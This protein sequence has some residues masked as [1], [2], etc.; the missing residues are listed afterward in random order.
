MGATAL[1]SPEPEG[2]FGLPAHRP[3][4]HHRAAVKLD[5]ITVVM[6]VSSTPS[7]M[8]NNSSRGSLVSVIS[9]PPTNTSVS[10]SPEAM[11]AQSSTPSLVPPPLTLPPDSMSPSYAVKSPSIH[12]AMS[13]AIS[14]S[15]SPS[16]LIRRLSRGAQSRI[17]R[18]RNSNTST[19][20]DQSAGPVIMR[21]RSNSNKLRSDSTLDV[22]DF[23][24]EPHGEVAVEDSADHVYSASL[25]SPETQAGSSLAASRDG[26]AP[27]VPAM[28][29]LGSRITKVTKRRGKP[30]LLQLD[31]DSGKVFWDPHKSSK[32]FYIDDI[33]YIRVGSEARE[34]REAAQ[35]SAECESRWFTVIF[36]TPDNAKGRGALRALHF[37]ADEP[38]TLQAWVDGINQIQQ[39]RIQTM[40][41][42]AKG[43]ENCLQELWRRETG[44]LDAD[45]TRL[46]FQAVNNLCK[47]LSINCSESLLRAHFNQADCGHV[48]SIDFDQFRSFV[49]KLRKRHDI[50]QVFKNAKPASK[51]ELD[52]QSFLDF[53]VNIQGIQVNSRL[54][55][56]TGT[57]ER[58][59]KR[60]R[61]DDEPRENPTTMNFAAFQDLMMHP[62]ISGATNGR[63][64]DKPLD[65][66]L[67]EYFVSS[68]H[69]TY[70]TGRQF[71]DDCSTEAY[72]S[73]LTR[74]CRCVEIDCWDGPGGRPEVRHGRNFTKPVL[75]SDCIHVINEHAFRSSA[76]PL[77]ISL[78]VHCS[79]PQ[80]AAMVEA[81]TS[82]FGEKL[83]TTPIDEFS[84]LPSPEQLKERILIKVKASAEELG[85]MALG[86]EGSASSSRYTHSPPMVPLSPD[87]QPP[88]SIALSSPASFTPVDTERPTAAPRESR[89]SSSATPLSPSSSAEESD[90]V[91]EK[92]RKVPSSNII[93]ALGDLGVYAKGIKYTGFKT[94][95]AKTFN[96]IY[97]F[98]EGTF[99]R[100]AMKATDS[101]S[102]MEKH[103]KRYLMRV[104][105][106]NLRL[107]S[108]NFD[109][110]KFWRR[111]VQMSALNW[112]THDH[113]MQINDAMFAAG[114]DQTG[115]VLKPLD[116]RVDINEKNPRP[117]KRLVRF[118]IDVIS[119][120]Q[121]PRP[122]N[123]GG[124][125]INPFVQLEVFTPEDRTKQ[126]SET[127]GAGAGSLRRRTHVVENNG[128][129]PTFHDTLSVAV[130]TC[131]PSLVFVR[132]TVHNSLDGRT[133]ASGPAPLATYTAKL[134]GL[135][136][137]YR[138]IPLN[139]A[140]N[141]RYYFAT[142]FCR[143][144]K[145]PV[146]LA[147]DGSETFEM[148]AP[149]T[150][151]E[152]G[153]SGRAGI[154]KRVFGRSSS[155]RK[156]EAAGGTVASPLPQGSPVH[157]S[158]RRV[159][160]EDSGLQS[161]R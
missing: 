159:A 105:P 37:I 110:L 142:L 68:S 88:P 161:S 44:A 94:S 130:E 23:E 5:G 52:L 87:T 25:P 99:E 7:A 132:L 65:R 117:L 97:S 90:F 18:R 10:A 43:G 6:P 108:D 101:E 12:S 154:F 82:I 76:Y 78:E 124:E 153:G 85:E 73:A 71:M 72:V 57:F 113:G 158:V 38:D 29:H 56:W 118:S 53:L 42:M 138:H 93:R 120:Q 103:N 8:S 92:K 114:D 4:R 62:S 70:L 145:L 125:G 84:V 17:S 102:I 75:F 16:S 24:L 95:Q 119:A 83:V 126:G 116:M 141:E 28:L 112:Q 115:Y 136:Q 137:G 47:T 91:S 135:Q 104:Y 129:D 146:G 22:S 14:M 30:I 140:A 66:P 134:D 133:H 67:N 160:S 131:Y 34:Y 152:A 31:F 156:K 40:A 3:S 106:S 86:M 20:R 77:I 111:G 60:F 41:D 89:N 19:S 149:A 69:N 64:S 49:K 63:T 148:A 58:Y 80:Q 143:V 26:W 13:E 1:S 122:R 100:I 107:Q 11:L 121:L 33:Q 36:L 144:N 2:D 55:Y 74:G 157:S 96:H 50:K 155:L 9:L 54:A 35:F 109:P 45:D 59:C 27:A 98:A 21:G 123:W 147:Q 51:K 151:S 39:L 127:V 139:N 79:P 150:V 32:Q 128:Y 15:R 61:K 46:G 81:M 48:G